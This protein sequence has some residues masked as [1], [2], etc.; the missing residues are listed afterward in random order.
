MHHFIYP[1]QDTFITN[2]QN[3]DTLNF[4]LNEILQVGT[5]G[6]T[7]RVTSPTT[8]VSFNQSASNLCVLNFSGFVDAEIYGTSSFA[9]GSIS[10]YSYITT[11]YYS[12]TLTGSYLSV[13]NE[14]SSSFTGSLTRFTGSFDGFAIGNVSASLQSYYIN[15]F[16]GSVSSFTG[17]ILSGY[18]NGIEILN[19]QN[20]S[21]QT[22][23]Y[24]NRALLQFDLSAISTSVASG[25]II[26]PHFTL[27][28]KTARSE[29]LPVKYS[30]Y[31]LPLSESWVMGNGYF[32]DGGSVNGASW[33]YRDSQ[34][35][36]AWSS[37]GGT[38]IT[39]YA[40]TQSFDY[41]TSDISMDVSNMVN[42]WI[43]GTLQNNGIM[44]I[45]GDEINSSSSEMSLYFFSEDTNTIY[46]PYIDVGWD[47]GSL[48]FSFVT[49]SVTTSSVLNFYQ[50]AGLNGIVSNSASLDGLIFGK[51]D[52]VGNITIVEGDVSAS[53]PV[54]GSC[55]GMINVVGTSDL[56]NGISIFGDFSGSISSSIRRIFK[57][58]SSGKDYHRTTNLPGGQDQSQ[59]QGH[60]IYGWGDSFNEF[61]QYDWSFPS[62]GW[63]PI[64]SG[65]VDPFFNYTLTEG[66]MGIESYL[67]EA[68]DFGYNLYKP[69]RMHY[70]CYSSL[71]TMSFINGTLFDGIFSG[72]NFTSFL[73]KGYQLKEGYLVGPWNESMIDGTIISADYP[74]LPLFPSAMN[75]LFSG[76]YVNGPAFGSITNTS[77]INTLYDSGIFDGVFTSGSLAGSKIHA[78]FSGSIL[79]ASLFIYSSIT[80]FSRSLNP[81]Q[82][83]SPFITV[84]NIPEKVKT[85]EIIKVKVFGREKFPLKNFQRLT[86]FSQFLTPLY[87]PSGSFYSIK[88]NETEEII[89]DFDNYTRLSCDTDGSY[90]ML[91]TSGLPQE[92][93]FKIL[94]KIEQSSSFY[95]Q[96]N[97]DIFK[98]VR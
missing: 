27:K 20:V 79:T 49:G 39:Q 65:D 74:F 36:T 71:V 17:K 64:L 82:V 85:N 91:D 56:I 43:T 55:W 95:I 98:V 32:F 50:P 60:D 12:G 16:S 40:G 51:F 66:S 70:P 31:A 45:S 37:S 54:S 24:F 90:F 97:N 26:S 72:S 86:Q 1:I 5:Q 59:Y 28:M 63:D 2:V 77:S 76:V 75:V 15:N 47:S 88:D 69:T 96:D 94:I 21:L 53:V 44:V 34:G 4:G 33:K 67:E 61:T 18:L 41:E 10:G 57:R 52:G 13:S 42:A 58:C 83:S 93:Y 22:S 25:D 9:L 29:N 73:I 84:V 7:F 3:L 62:D 92:R 6:V 30:I 80:Y 78:P 87:L 81:L 46:S 19:Q 68:N 8:S 23:S 35:G 38:F 11:S 89:L 48:G 14:S